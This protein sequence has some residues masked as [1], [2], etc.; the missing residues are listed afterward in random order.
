MEEKETKPFAELENYM[1]NLIWHYIFQ[2]HIYHELY[3][4]A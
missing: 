1:Y 3:R 4:N 2:V